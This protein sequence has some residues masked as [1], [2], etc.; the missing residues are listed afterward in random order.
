[1]NDYISKPV[2]ERVLYKK[3]VELLKKRLTW[4]ENEREIV[5]EII[6]KPD[7]TQ[8]YTDLNYL[9]KR[10]KNDYV[11]I[12]EMIKLYLDQTPLL[13]DNMKQSQASKDWES[14]YSAAH[15]IIP[16]F[17]IMGMNKEYENIAIKIQEY[18][19][20]KQNLDKIKGLILQLD[21]ACSESYLELKEEYEKIESKIK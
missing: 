6:H 11:L 14:L 4:G 20:Q 3:M 9:Y 18:S 15:K 13:L 21:A 1:M 7:D 8:K 12:M 10:T 16:S 17:S 2:D 5:P 19:F